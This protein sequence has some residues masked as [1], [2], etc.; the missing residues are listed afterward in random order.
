MRIRWWAVTIVGAC[1]VNRKALRTLASLELSSDSSSKADSPIIAVWSTSMGCA[2]LTA[3]MT[4]MI[5]LGIRRLARRNPS[6]SANWAL[7]GSSPY[8]TR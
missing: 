7:L 5:S 4:V 8:S 3:S 2:D 6:I 1:A